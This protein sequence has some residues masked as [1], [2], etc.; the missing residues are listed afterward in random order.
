MSTQ[1]VSFKLDHNYAPR[2]NPIFKATVVSNE[3]LVSIIE[4]SDSTTIAIVINSDQIATI[5]IVS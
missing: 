5:A 1:F 3:L 2:S 4:L